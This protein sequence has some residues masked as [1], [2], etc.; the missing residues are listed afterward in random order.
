MNYREIWV[1]REKD[2]VEGDG[3]EGGHNLHDDSFDYDSVDRWGPWC[4]LVAPFC[5]LF[6]GN[7]KVSLYNRESK[8]IIPWARIKTKKEDSGEEFFS[9][10]LEVNPCA[11]FPP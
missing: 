10:K 4:P 6:D 8:I 11:V 5:I 1:E 7:V 3:S 9:V 2:L